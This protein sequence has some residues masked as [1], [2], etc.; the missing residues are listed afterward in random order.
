M[1]DNGTIRGAVEDT[2]KKYNV[3]SKHLA[4]KEREHSS[5]IQMFE[6][7]KS[8]IE[9]FKND[10]A[11]AK[12]E[13]EA[14]RAN[15]QKAT[16]KLGTAEEKLGATEAKLL[17]VSQ[18]KDE[19][20][21]KA[22][23]LKTSLRAST[24]NCEKVKKALSAAELKMRELEQQLEAGAQKTD[25]Y[26][27]QRLLG[28]IAA[29]ENKIAGA[30]T[31]Q[32]NVSIA[33]EEVFAMTA[34]ANNVIERDHVDSGIDTALTATS[35]DEADDN[36]L[37]KP[38]QHVRDVPDKAAKRLKKKERK[39]KKK[40]RKQTKK[41]EKAA[42]ASKEAS[43]RNEASKTKEV[44]KPKSEGEVE[45]ENDGPSFNQRCFA[46]YQKVDRFNVGYMRLP[47]STEYATPPDLIAKEDI[48]N[49]TPKICMQDKSIIPFIQQHARAFLDIYDV[50]CP[51][52]MYPNEKYFG[53]QEEN[54]TF[55]I[56]PSPMF[57]EKPQFTAF[58]Y[59]MDVSG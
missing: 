10:I 13:A 23:A 22:I 8:K 57:A 18:E 4:R 43:K 32:N 41:K 31:A 35:A 2:N 5:L 12:A 24:Q 21:K 46:N 42:S 51:M 48:P 36:T 26:E 54:G 17:A 28:I 45:Q 20:T 27:V 44:S 7:A 6:S 55:I 56:P 53:F 19:Q 14:S 47:F 3:V 30:A 49:D 33:F 58:T 15:E 50:M 29:I 39:Q 40:E 52:E 37:E 34:T 11:A 59:T 1:K 38:E 16:A 9:R 25:T